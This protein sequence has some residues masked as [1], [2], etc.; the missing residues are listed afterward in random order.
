MKT[1]PNCQR[2]ECPRTFPA[3]LNFCQVCGDKLTDEV[4][5]GG[6]DDPFKT[7]LAPMD[8]QPESDFDPMKTMLASPPSLEIPPPSPF[9]DSQSSGGQSGGIDL[10]KPM[11][12]D[13]S[14]PQFSN[15]P[16]PPQ[17]DPFGS[18]GFGQQQ[19]DS[20]QFGNSPS[21]PS[22]QEPPS[23]SP[24][25]SQPNFGGEPFGQTPAE[26]TPPPSPTDWGNQ[27]LGSNTPFTPPPS[28]FGGQDQTLGI[29]SL[30]CGIIAMLCCYVGFLLGPAAL[31]T[32]FMTLKNVQ[33]DPQRYGGKGLAI[34]GMI[35]GGIGTLISVL[36][37]IYLIVVFGILFSG[38]MR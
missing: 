36:Y 25:G 35:T 13:L 38:G 1:N 22:F 3:S 16:A 20:G 29:V 9:G 24:F 7:V 15:E 33:K 21:I 11:S 23:Q 8:N 26:W 28:G 27:G 37:F 31:I 10:N 4:P 19:Q 30:V 32:G 2:S 17:N 12:G 6:S 18:G 34:G 14:S 5:I